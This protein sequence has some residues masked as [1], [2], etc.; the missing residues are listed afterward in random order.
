M[1]STLLEGDAAD[2]VAALKSQSDENLTILASATLVQSLMRPDL[3]DGL[4]LMIHPLV[5]GSA[6]DSSRTTVRRTRHST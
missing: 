1:N 2:A 3:V 4:V 5:L 6:D